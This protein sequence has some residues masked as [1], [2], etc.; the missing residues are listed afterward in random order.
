MV[1]VMIEF[2]VGAAESDRRVILEG[3]YMMGCC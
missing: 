1:E 3:G 2:A